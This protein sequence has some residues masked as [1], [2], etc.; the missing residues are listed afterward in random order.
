MFHD[1][2]YV[3][4]MFILEKEYEEVYT[5]FLLLPPYIR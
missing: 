3:Y 2:L 1:Y 5:F 4:T